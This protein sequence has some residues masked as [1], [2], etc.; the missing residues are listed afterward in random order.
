MPRKSVAA[1][2]R[3]DVEKKLLE[4]ELSKYQELVRALRTSSEST[5]ARTHKQKEY[6]K[7]IL[8]LQSRIE[9]LGK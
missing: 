8:E 5:L 2:A 7:K 3:F 4:A 1:K 9:K 6:H